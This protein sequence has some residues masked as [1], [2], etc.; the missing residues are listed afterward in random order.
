MVGIDAGAVVL[1]LD[2]F[3]NGNRVRQIFHRLP[4]VQ[5]GLE[6]IGF[7]HY[8]ACPA[9]PALASLPLAS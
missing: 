6:R 7:I 9:V 8:P 5:R 4:A 3:L 1:A 2:N